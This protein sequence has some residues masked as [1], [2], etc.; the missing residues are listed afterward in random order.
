[1]AE[2]QDDLEGQ[3][4]LERLSFPKINYIQR[5]TLA[6]PPLNNFA[7]SLSLFMLAAPMMGWCKYESPT[8]GTCVGIGGIALYFCGFYDWYQRHSMAA[9]MDFIFAFLNLTIYET[10]SLG[11]FY[12]G[13]GSVTVP[14]NYYSHLQG[15]F[16]VI[17]FIGVLFLILGMGGKGALNIVA[18]TFFALGLVFVIVWEYS[19]HTWSRKMAG[20]IIFIG[21]IFF[22]I[23]GIGKLLQRV[24]G[25]P[26]L[27]AMTPAF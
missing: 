10:A 19:H 14:H 8:L 5:S 7:I 6:A 3:N 18:F 20:Y 12:D 23:C 16:Y 27:P 24:F 2:N 22:W 21:T 4:Q 17:Y 15:T 11:K 25:L 1:M 9:F 26:E 13:V